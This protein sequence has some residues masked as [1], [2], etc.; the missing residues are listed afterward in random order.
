MIAMCLVPFLARHRPFANGSGRL[1]DLFARSVDLG[2]GERIVQTSDGFDI[3]VLAGD[4]IGRH[5]LLSGRFERSVV[6]VLLDHARLGDVLLDIG[7]NIGYAAACFL[8]RVSGSTAI[9]V[10]P[11]PEIADL[12]RSTLAQQKPSDHPSGRIFG[13]L[14]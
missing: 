11:Q 7:A 2:G 13:P 8:S 1:L 6:Q 9:C 5:L 3:K 12:L 14:G 4:L 10:E